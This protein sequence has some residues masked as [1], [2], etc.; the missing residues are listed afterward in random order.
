MFHQWCARCGTWTGQTRESSLVQSHI[1]IVP[2]RLDSLLKYVL[3]KK[4]RSKNGG[5]PKYAPLYWQELWSEVA[6]VDISPPGLQ[7]GD[8][9]SGVPA[10]IV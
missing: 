7:V 1:S 6:Q 8:N 3:I 9:V 2:G 4:K 5:P 10:G